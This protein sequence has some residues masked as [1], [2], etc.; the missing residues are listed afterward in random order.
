[1]A[2]RD[3]FHQTSGSSSGQ[4]VDN[5]EESSNPGKQPLH[6]LEC[7]KAGKASRVQ[8]SVT[9]LAGDAEAMGPHPPIQ[10][11][12]QGLPRAWAL[13]GLLWNLGL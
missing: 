7:S 1:M 5:Y 6:H 11:Q 2:T 3:P 12:L 9:C 8:E 13:L 4:L 10:A